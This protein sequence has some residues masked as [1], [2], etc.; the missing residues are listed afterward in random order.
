MIC[1]LYK[2]M[3]DPELREAHETAVR[4]VNCIW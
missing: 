3:A 1:K 4:I 2:I